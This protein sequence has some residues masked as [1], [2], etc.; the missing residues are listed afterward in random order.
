MITKTNNP[1]IGTYRV[2]NEIFAMIK[3]IDPMTAITKHCLRSLVLESEKS[4]EP[5]IKVIKVGA[6][7]LICFESVLDYFGLQREDKPYAS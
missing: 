1:N 3:A 6:K 5:K 7:R 4:E 2:L